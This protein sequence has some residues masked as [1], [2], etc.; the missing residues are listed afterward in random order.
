MGM[1][2]TEEA[3]DE[4]AGLPCRLW[5]VVASDQLETAE[6]TWLELARECS[7]WWEWPE[8]GRHASGRGLCIGRGGTKVESGFTWGIP[9]RGG[10][11]GPETAV[12]YWLA[13]SSDDN[14]SEESV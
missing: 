6:L 12:P 1:C 2:L 11:R 3:W 5:A 14:E 7:C 13:C 8:D 9:L 4:L 10:G